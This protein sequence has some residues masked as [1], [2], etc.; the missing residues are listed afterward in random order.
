MDLSPGLARHR[1]NR[2]AMGRELLRIMDI[3]RKM[4][5]ARNASKSKCGCSNGKALL[6]AACKLADD[7][8]PLL[9]WPATRPAVH[10]EKASEEESLE[11]GG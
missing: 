9:A 5:T 2:L 1:R 8:K 4:A 10:E 7:D 3:L 11:P 6:P